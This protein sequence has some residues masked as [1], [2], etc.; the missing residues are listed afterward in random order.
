M[1][2]R[3]VARRLLGSK[4]SEVFFRNHSIYLDAPVCLLWEKET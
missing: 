4:Y 3:D 1:S 2:F